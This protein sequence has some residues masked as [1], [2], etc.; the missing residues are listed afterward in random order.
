MTSNIYECMN[1]IGKGEF[2]KIIKA[3]N[4]IT[5]ELVAIKQNTKTIIYCYMKVK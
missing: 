5:N 4:K 3:R 1:I 2:G